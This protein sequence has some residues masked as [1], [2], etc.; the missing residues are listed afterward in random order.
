MWV[1]PM[2]VLGAQIFGAFSYRLINI[3]PAQRKQFIVN[4]LRTKN[5]HFYTFGVLHLDKTAF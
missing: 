3:I 5:Y 4:E 2:Q 1:S